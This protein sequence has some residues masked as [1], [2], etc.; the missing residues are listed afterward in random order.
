[1][2]RKNFKNTPIKNTK[3]SDL[4]KKEYIC[5]TCKTLLSSPGNLNKHVKNFH[6]STSFVCSQCNTSFVSQDN[7]NRHVEKFHIKDSYLKEKPHACIPCKTYFSSQ[8]NLNKH[9]KTTHKKTPNEPRTFVIQSTSYSELLPYTTQQTMASIIF[10]SINAQ[11]FI[12]PLRLSL[13]HPIEE[14]HLFNFN[15]SDQDSLLFD[16]TS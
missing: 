10:P 16:K 9:I 5:T 1:M 13:E 6:K 11:K 14:E 4:Q 2:I 7:L 12:P 8:G 3:A 15:T